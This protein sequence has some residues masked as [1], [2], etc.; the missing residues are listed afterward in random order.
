MTIAVE[1][2]NVPL[3]S[4]TVIKERAELKINLITGEKTIVEVMQ[5][6]HINQILTN[7]GLK[8]Q[9]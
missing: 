2:N 6:C 8:L 1:M 5:R 7:L 9:Q 3:D 4:V